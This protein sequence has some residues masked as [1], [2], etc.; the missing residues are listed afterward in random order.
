MGKIV[1]I[2]IVLLLAG[3]LSALASGIRFHAE[4]LQYYMAYTQ[5]Q[6][7]PAAH[8]ESAKS[9]V[10][11]ANGNVLIGTVLSQTD[12]S[13]EVETEGVA[14]KFLPAEIRE[15]IKA[16]VSEVAATRGD[17]KKELDRIKKEHPL[18]TQKKEDTL[19]AAW[20]YWL[21]E[22]SRLAEEIRE[23]NP[24]ISATKQMELME[25]EM[26]QAAQARRAMMQAQERAAE[27]SY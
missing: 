17:S 18:F 8:D 1:L 3:V 4:N 12:D 25:K 5:K 27:Q 20:D 23:K 24:Q 6:S 9:K 15:I 21:T 7:F 13:V 19:K 14:I 26:R 22:P 11:L 16:D 2:A 10:M